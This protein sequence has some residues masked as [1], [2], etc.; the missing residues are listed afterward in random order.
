MSNKIKQL[1]VM[2]LLASILTAELIVVNVW[3][4]IEPFALAEADV[5]KAT[6]EG[7]N[8]CLGCALK[9]QEA[10]A[11]Q[12]SILGHEHALEV[13]WAV[14][15]DSKELTGMGDWILYYIETDNDQQSIKEHGVDTLTI[16]GKVYL[17]PRERELHV[18]CLKEAQMPKWY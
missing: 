17:Y 16:T 12:C 11:E 15:E 14:A 13:I 3:K 9:E 8:F 7:T 1:R 18:D 4:R 2:L 5:A 6:L 10:V